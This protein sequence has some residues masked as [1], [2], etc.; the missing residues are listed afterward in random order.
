[1]L[2]TNNLDRIQDTLFF[3]IKAYEHRKIN[4]T[5]FQI[6]W[7]YLPLLSAAFSSKNTETGSRETTHSESRGNKLLLSESEN[8]P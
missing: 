5:I 3:N 8:N 1:M 2:K 4:L 6:F 7:L